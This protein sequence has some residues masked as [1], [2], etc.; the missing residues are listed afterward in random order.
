M[1]S[2]LNEDRARIAVLQR[3][4]D[5]LNQQVA[6][7][8]RSRPGKP[9]WVNA[10]RGALNYALELMRQELAEREEHARLDERQPA[11]ISVAEWLGQR[12]SPIVL[13]AA[14]RM[15]QQRVREQQAVA[16]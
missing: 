5:R 15:A 4:L 9:G 13:E 7:W 14:L 11:R 6:E 2:K 8:D 12:Y 10:E 16:G 1:M 3:R